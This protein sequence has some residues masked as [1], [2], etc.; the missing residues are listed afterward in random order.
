MGGKVANAMVAAARQG[1]HANMVGPVSSLENRAILWHEGIGMKWTRPFR[2][3]RP[4]LVYDFRSPNGN[5]DFLRRGNQWPHNEP[6][7][8]V[9]QFFSQEPAKLAAIDGIYLTLEF[10]PK[11]V[12]DII[13]MTKDLTN[14]SI[15]WNMSPA[16]RIYDPGQTA[17]LGM[18][19][20]I[21]VNQAETEE[22]S[23]GI[24][25]IDER[26]AVNAAR[27][28]IKRHHLQRIAVTIGDQGLLSVGEDEEAVYVPSFHIRREKD[29]T[30]SGD[31]TAAAIMAGHLREGVITKDTLANAGL[32]GA[33]V[34]ARGEGHK[35]VPTRDELKGDVVIHDGYI[36]PQQEIADYLTL[37][38]E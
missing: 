34:A 6:R 36:I 19:D 37:H 12:T 27:R 32:V 10:D 11:L 15:Y 30:A 17:T 38:G 2:R 22:L 25:I 28:A 3:D 33:I 13:L 21:I 18:C 14:A 5:F 4:E 20:V 29:A 26:T 8:L 16:Y 24:K 7:K 31:S 35:G 23:G 1:L 9:D